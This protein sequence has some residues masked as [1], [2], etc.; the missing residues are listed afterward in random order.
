MKKIIQN[1]SR[2]LWLVPAF[3][4]GLSFVTPAFVTS[5]GA[6]DYGIKAGTAATKTEEMPESLFGEDGSEG[7]FK[8]VVNI[9]LFVIGAV[10]VIMLIYGGVKYVVSGGAQD[11]VAE[12]KNTILYAIVGIVVAI[13]AFAVV[14]FVVT[15]LAAQ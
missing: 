1:I 7:I 12:A 6:T 11:K 2:S 9:M 3:V 13:L 5:V 14:N 4:F 15:G 10:A 8:K